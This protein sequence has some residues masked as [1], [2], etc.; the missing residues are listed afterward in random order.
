MDEELKENVKSPST[1]RRALFMVLYA[2]FYGFGE[3]VLFL[4]VVFQFLHSLFTGGRNEMALEFS[5][6]LCAWLY[7]V[8]LY[9]TYNSEDQPFPF[10]PWPNE[11]VFAQSPLYDTDQDDFD[12]DDID[13]LRDDSASAVGADRGPELEVVK[14]ASPARPASPVPPAEPESVAA[15]ASTA[16]SEPAVDGSGQPDEPRRP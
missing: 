14:A 11:S 2:V 4:V 15:D 10:G 6:N 5:E 1:W 16:A 9:L 12:D 13:D 7:E 3:A 8:M